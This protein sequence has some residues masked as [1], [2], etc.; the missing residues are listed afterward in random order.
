MKGSV[1]ATQRV[2]TYSLEGLHVLRRVRT[3]C[4]GPIS[5]TE[6]FKCCQCE[7]VANNQYQF[8]IKLGNDN[9]GTGYNTIT[10]NIIGITKVSRLVNKNTYTLATDPYRLWNSY[11][12]L[13]PLPSAFGAAC[14]D[15]PLGH[16]S[17]TVGNHNS[18]G[19]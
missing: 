5:S 18:A 15:S 16:K 8:P 11:S 7:N 4:R 19:L 2:S 1:R 9:I 3:F 17:E 14:E 13:T 12:E 6:I 10:S